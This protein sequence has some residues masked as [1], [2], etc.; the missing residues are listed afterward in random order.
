[1]C[2]SY[3]TQ[4]VQRPNLKAV[5]TQVFAKPAPIAAAENSPATPVAGH[6]PAN[7]H[8]DRLSVPPTPPTPQKPRTPGTF[9]ETECSVIPAWKLFAAD[10]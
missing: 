6:T 1:M 5:I 9:V 10:W 3:T 4:R 7:A 8:T 2:Q